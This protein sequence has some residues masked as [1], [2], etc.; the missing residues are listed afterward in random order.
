MSMSISAVSVPCL[1]F[2]VSSA[3]QSF[4]VRSQSS[5]YFYVC[6]YNFIYIHF[7]FIFMCF[8]VC[9]VLSVCLVKWGVWFLGK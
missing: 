6:I 8:S 1:E 7:H 5:L 3:Y 4:G 9:I 2:S